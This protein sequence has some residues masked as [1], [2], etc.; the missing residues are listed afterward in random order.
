MEHRGG[1]G[2]CK[3]SGGSEAGSGGHGGKGSGSERECGGEHCEDCKG[4]C[5]EGKHTHQGGGGRLRG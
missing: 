5:E 1:D 3:G 4:W 2:D